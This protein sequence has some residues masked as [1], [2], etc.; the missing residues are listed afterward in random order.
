MYLIS[1][2]EI[3]FIFCFKVEIPQNVLKQ[4]LLDS[5]NVYI[6]DCKS[7]LFVW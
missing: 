7:D 2:C 1:E 6:L 4:K 5:K 3:C